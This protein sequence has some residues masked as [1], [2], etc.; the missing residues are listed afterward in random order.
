MF[1]VVLFCHRF[2]VPRRMTDAVVIIEKRLSI[3]DVNKCG[4]VNSWG[5]TTGRSIGAFAMVY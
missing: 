2:R 3:N 5:L 4:V 1:Y